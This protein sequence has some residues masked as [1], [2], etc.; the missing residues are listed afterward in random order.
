MVGNG[1]DHLQQVHQLMYEQHKLD[2]TNKINFDL[3]EHV[4]D[5]AD[6]LLKESK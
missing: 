5:E 3:L 2:K 1:S 6:F 4:R